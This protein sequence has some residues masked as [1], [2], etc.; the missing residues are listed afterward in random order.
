MGAVMTREELDEVRWMVCCSRGGW[1]ARS[2]AEVAAF[3]GRATEAERAAMREVWEGGPEEERE[4]LREWL[5]AW[6]EEDEG[7]DEGEDIEED[8]GEPAD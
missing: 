3:W 5:P 2:R 7:G 8:G 1:H 6:P 4:R